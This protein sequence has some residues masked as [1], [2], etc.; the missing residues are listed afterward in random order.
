VIGYFG[1][2]S[3]AS[4][5][6]AETRVMLLS[7]MLN[8]TYCIQAMFTIPGIFLTLQDSNDVLIFSYLSMS[9]VSLGDS[10]TNL[11]AILKARDFKVVSSASTLELEM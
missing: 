3:V 5:L 8:S 10:L 1:G 2:H 11:I 4:K 9:L 6:T 7:V